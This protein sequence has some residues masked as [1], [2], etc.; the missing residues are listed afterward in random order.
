MSVKGVNIVFVYRFAPFFAGAT[1]P[2]ERTRFCALF[3]TFLSV[4]VVENAYDKFVLKPFPIA[5][6]ASDSVT[7]DESRLPNNLVLLFFGTIG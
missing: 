7:P 5:M 1:D 2:P 6:F 4:V 3:I